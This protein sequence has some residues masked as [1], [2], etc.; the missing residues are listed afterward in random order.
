MTARRSRP[1]PPSLNTWHEYPQLSMLREDFGA[2]I[3]P[4][5]R[6]HQGAYLVEVDGV[7]SSR[8]ERSLA[9]LEGGPGVDGFV[10]AVGDR[11]LT[12]GEI[13]I[14]VVTED[15]DADRMPFRLFEVNDVRQDASGVLFQELPAKAELPVGFEAD[16]TW[17]DPLP[18]DSEALVHAVLPSEYP[19]ELL[20]PIVSGLSE[21]P[22]HMSPDWTVETT[23]HRPPKDAPYDFEEARRIARQHILQVARPIGWPAREMHL[24]DRRVVSEY[25][26]I[27]R[28]LRFLHFLASVRAS[29]EAALIDV[30]A[31]VEQKLGMSASVT[32]RNVYT[33]EDVSQ[34]V[35][36]FKAGGVPLTAMTDILLQ[37]TQVSKEGA[38]RLL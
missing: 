32:A 6:R 17:S 12:V 31:L 11:L 16:S 36:R 19:K 37:E 25:Y 30:L 34:I 14:E 38:R 15:D 2:R 26:L 4:F 13:W 28:E 8:V 18:L 7:A 33:S 10:R 3:V 22:F 1:I 35:S 23:E 5:Q 21:I 27:L 9:T 24:T 29:A 20:S